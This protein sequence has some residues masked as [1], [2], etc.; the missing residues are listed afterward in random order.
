MINKLSSDQDSSPSLNQSRWEGTV[1]NVEGFSYHASTLAWAFPIVGTKSNIGI[2][3]PAL[4]IAY[5]TGRRRRI[6]S[7]SQT[8]KRC[9][10]KSEGVRPLLEQIYILVTARIHLLKAARIW[11]FPRMFGPFWSEFMLF[12]WMLTLHTKEW[13]TRNWKDSIHQSVPG[14]HLNSLE[15][16]HNSCPR[17]SNRFKTNFRSRNPFEAWEV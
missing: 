2:Q 10:K 3:I 5:S 1:K 6:V 17:G 14:R 12:R 13:W 7:F 8:W 9:R 11:P 4:I 16:P 15:R